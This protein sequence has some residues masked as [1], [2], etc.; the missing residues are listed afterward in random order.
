MSPI[1]E[2]V[3]FFSLSLLFPTFVHDLGL[4][5]AVVVALEKRND[6]GRLPGSWGAVDASPPTSRHGQGLH[7]NARMGLGSV[8]RRET[9]TA[10]VKSDLITIGYG[11]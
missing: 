1:G 3:F 6:G 11:I 4:S 5:A 8:W 2:R 10:N 9:V 7:L